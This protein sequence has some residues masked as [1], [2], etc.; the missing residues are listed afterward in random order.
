MQ[1]PRIGDT[2][3]YRSYGTPGGEFKAECR[4]AMVTAVYPQTPAAVGDTDA[5][6]LCVLNPT[7]FFFHDVARH[8]EGAETPG[9]PGC[10][11]R[12][13]HGGPHRYCACGWIE[14]G[15]RGG[16]WHDRE[17]CAT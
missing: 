12:Q 13:F 7:G 8:D 3:H 6:S 5:V 14:G 4:A 16:T 11:N 9:A 2:V 10:P 17:H 15:Y 1:K